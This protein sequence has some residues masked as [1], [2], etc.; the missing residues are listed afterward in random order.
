MNTYP[1]LNQS[2]LQEAIIYLVER[3]E[4]L[5]HIYVQFGPPPLWEREPGFATLILIILEQQVSL[6]SAKAAYQRLLASVDCLTPEAFLSLEAS[7]LRQIGFSRQKGR[8]GRLLA[9]AILQGRLN[10][11]GLSKLN[12]EA[13]KAELTKITGIGPWTANIYLLMALLRPDVWPKGDIALTTAWQ[14]LKKLD[15]R[16]SQDTLA[17]LSLV[18]QPWRAVA[19]RL[20][21]H[22]Y[23]NT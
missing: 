20:L 5:A 11:D 19:A 8:Y 9:E 6:A 23:L 3:D 21:W 7:K 10:L 2:N 16:P 12:D 1:T 14:R 22:Y 18:W 13:A 15:S 4:D 17:E